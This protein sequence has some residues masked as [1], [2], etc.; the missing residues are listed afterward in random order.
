LSSGVNDFSQKRVYS[1]PIF[2]VFP[3]ELSLSICHMQVVLDFRTPNLD[4]VHSWRTNISSNCTVAA[5][6]KTWV[7]GRSLAEIEGSNP[8]GGV[9]VCLLWMS[10]V[11]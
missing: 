11:R 10:V 2:S 1:S 4:F 5:R 6:S 8:A 7:C 3:V 9:D